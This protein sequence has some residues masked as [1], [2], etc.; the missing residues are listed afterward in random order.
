MSI[1]RHLKHTNIKLVARTRKEIIDEQ[2]R[3]LNEILRDRYTIVA[4][5]Y[6][7][8]PERV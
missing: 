5:L 4:V 8:L 3:S 1:T 6:L 7:D 2:S